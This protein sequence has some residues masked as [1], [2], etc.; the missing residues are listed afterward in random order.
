MMETKTD[1]PLA[2]EL[3]AG[4]IYNSVVSLRR[5]IEGADGLG[6]ERVVELHADTVRVL[7]GLFEQLTGRRP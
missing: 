4:M 1:N 6:V 3:A 2:R 7:E 5:A